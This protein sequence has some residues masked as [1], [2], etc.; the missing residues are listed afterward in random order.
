M[1]SFV[2]LVNQQPA[3]HRMLPQKRFD[4]GPALRSNPDKLDGL[5]PELRD[6]FVP[7]ADRLRFGRYVW[8]KL[9]N[10]I[11]P[12][13]IRP[14]LR[15]FGRSHNPAPVDIRSTIPRRNGKNKETR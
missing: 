15:R 9:Q 12:C 6:Q 10:R 3:I 13:Q 4:C 8:Q 1:R 11:L 5:I 14:V 7:P 2:F